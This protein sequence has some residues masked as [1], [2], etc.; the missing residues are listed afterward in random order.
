MI[1][2][3]NDEPRL[4]EASL[5]TTDEA[6]DHRV[7]HKA[8]DPTRPAKVE[9]GAMPSAALVNIVIEVEPVAG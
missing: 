6:L 8:D 7:A 2:S 1:T 9:S 4:E 5:P 3:C